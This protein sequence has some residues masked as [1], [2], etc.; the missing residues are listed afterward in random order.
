MEEAAEKISD[1]DSTV[2]LV[3]AAHTFW[4]GLM[5]GGIKH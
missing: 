3:W 1:G 4:Y 5:T 2:L